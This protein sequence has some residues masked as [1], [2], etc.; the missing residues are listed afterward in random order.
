MLSKSKYAI[1][2]L[3]S[4]VILCCILKKGKEGYTL[5]G[6]NKFIKI[7][8]AFRADECQ[9]EC[10]KDPHCK[11]VNRPSKL[12][13]WEKGECWKSGQYDQHITG[14]QQTGNFKKKMVC[15]FILKV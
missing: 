7:G 5:L 13:S 6:D 15:G 3:L 1:F 10:E 2:G 12:K 14:P 4:I 11:Y 8:N 9:T